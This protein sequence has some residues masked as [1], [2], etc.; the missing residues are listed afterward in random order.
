MHV[1]VLCMLNE[2]LDA[3]A[4]LR[5]ICQAYSSCPFRVC[6]RL[7]C[8]SILSVCPWSRSQ[9]DGSIPNAVSAAVR[10][11]QALRLRIR[12]RRRTRRKGHSTSAISISM[13]SSSTLT[14][15]IRTT[16]IPVQRPP[17]AYRRTRM[18]SSITYSPSTS[19]GTYVFACSSR[20]V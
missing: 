7:T 19:P 16:R 2:M 3:R 12:L 5:S 15:G 6:R 18:F 14:I 4:A 10:P 20:A 1:N 13:T 9:L 11:I 8:S 17:S